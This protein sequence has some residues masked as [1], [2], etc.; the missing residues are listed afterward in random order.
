[1]NASRCSSGIAMNVQLRPTDN[2][3]GLDLLS[4]MDLGCRFSLRAARPAGVTAS[5]DSR[6]HAGEA[7][8]SRR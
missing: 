3:S 2:W 6:Q 4:T 5:K 7:M 8:S 1:M